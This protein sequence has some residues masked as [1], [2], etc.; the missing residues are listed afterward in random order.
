MKYIVTLLTSI[1]LSKAVIALD[2]LKLN[3]SANYIYTKIDDPIYKNVDKY[4]AFDDLEGENNAYRN[5]LFAGIQYTYDD[6]IISLST[7]RPFNT[8]ITAPVIRRADNVPFDNKVHIDADILKVLYKV[9]KFAIGGLV[10]NTE[11]DKQLYYNDS[12][13]GEE[14]VNTFN[15]G[16]DFTYTFN[17]KLSTSVMLILPNDEIYLKGGAGV[18]LS[19]SF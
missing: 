7:N 9:N 19:Y 12:F 18:N 14:I 16:F 10:I 3:I 17:K 13:V 11:I 1:F 4:D 8:R 5:L 2:N 15:F 6:F